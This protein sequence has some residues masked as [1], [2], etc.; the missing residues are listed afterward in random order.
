MTILIP[1][2]RLWSVKVLPRSSPLLTRLLSTN[3][4][5]R[6]SASEPGR[7]VS[8]RP[9]CSSAA[10]PTLFQ[11]KELSEGAKKR[12]E[13]AE[14]TELKKQALLSGAPKALPDNAWR[15][16]F[17]ERGPKKGEALDKSGSRT[18]ATALEYR[19]I[20]AEER[21]RLN[22]T[23]NENKGQNEAA[24]KEWVQSHTPLQIKQAN[25]ARDLLRQD[26]KK[27]G[28]KASYPHIKDERLVKLPHNQFSL[29]LK[30]RFESGDLKGLSIAEAGRAVAREWK[31]LSPAE[32]R[33][34]NERFA[35][36]RSRYQEEYKTVY[37]IDP[38]SFNSSSASASP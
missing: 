21:E 31:D 1:V 30:D 18:K 6:V 35:A 13:A 12:K 3:S 24:Y 36:D 14:R 23:A 34:Y 4:N 26:G 37:G 27:N 15:V 22:H 20:S 10:P 29:F 19:T 25:H 28:K 9:Q 38:P 5:R 11:Q 16:F 32:K 2:G 33:A 7:T 8:A 17:V